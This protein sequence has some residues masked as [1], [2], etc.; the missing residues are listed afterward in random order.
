[1]SSVR[2]QRWDA[3]HAGVVHRTRA[4]SNYYGPERVGPSS[5]AG[6]PAMHEAALTQGLV[7][8]LLKEAARHQVR[9]ITL[10]RL[11]VGRMKAVEPQAL[12][13]CFGAFTEGTLAEGA[14]LII[15]PVPAVAT[16]RGCGGDFEV[17]KF[18]FQCPRC[19][20]RDVVLIQ[21]DELYIES[22]DA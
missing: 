20:S 7:N 13:F 3:G 4:R 6:E 15:E 11:K 17:I 16:C 10:V 1:M 8:I 2:R 19:Q 21:G 14:E 5:A 22:F 12:V 9:S 18:H